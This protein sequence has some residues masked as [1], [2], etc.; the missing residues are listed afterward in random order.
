MIH[1]QRT[2]ATPADLVTRCAA[3]APPGGAPAAGGG[4]GGQARRRGAGDKNGGA[5]P[6]TDARSLAPPEPGSP[7]RLPGAGRGSAD[8]E[9]AGAVRVGAPRPHLAPAALPVPAEHLL[10]AWGHEGQDVVGGLLHRLVALVRRLGAHRRLLHL[11]LRPRRGVVEAAP[12]PPAGVREEAQ[13]G[14]AV[15]LRLAALGR[16]KRPEH[17]RDGAQGHGLP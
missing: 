13:R 5:P 3:R 11:L 9:V 15:A 1:T 10:E 12:R 7:P 16:L 8:A 6:P 14:Q 17:P 4:P 2:R